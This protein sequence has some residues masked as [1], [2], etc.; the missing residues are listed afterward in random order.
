MSAWKPR[1]WRMTVRARIVLGHVLPMIP[2]AVLGLFT[3]F[4]LV[5]MTHVAN[6]TRTLG[7]ERM[8]DMASAVDLF[9]E[10]AV[11]MARHMESGDPGLMA[12]AK[13][14]STTL[15]THLALVGPLNDLPEDPL[16]LLLDDFE[17]L[18][19]MG[20]TM[21]DP[22]EVD[23]QARQLLRKMRSRHD[24]VRLELQ[25]GLKGL[26]VMGRTMATGVVLAVGLLVVSGTLMGLWMG[27]S[28]IDDLEVLERGTTALAA[29]DFDHRIQ[30]HREDEFGQLARAFNRMAAK[31]GAL[32]QMKADFFA[33][34]SH[35]LK[36]P[37][38]SIVEAVDLLE[39]EVAGPLTTRQRR[40]TGV[41]KESATRLKSLV[42]NLLDV[43]RIGARNLELTPGEVVTALKATISELSLLSARKE[44][45]VI[46]VLEGHGHVVLANR[47]MLEQVLMNVVGNAIRY[48]PRGGRVEVEVAHVGP[49]QLRVDGERGVRICVM[50]EGPGIPAA[51]R[52]QVFDRFF[53]VP[54]HQDRTGT[55]LGLYIARQIVESHGGIIEV[56][57]SPAG[58]AAVAFT[59]VAAAPLGV[60]PRPDELGE[61]ADADLETAE[62][63]TLLSGL[64]VGR[65][66]KGSE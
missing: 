15:R 44:V 24:R 41:L 28:L 57:T 52:E 10:E 53:R 42:A 50:D 31:I 61:V 49:E 40:L 33:N 19:G 8:D 18:S 62:G 30:L 14:R 26:G 16:V 46:L 21:G 38:T 36:T 48:S 2:I 27:R 58:G 23:R 4:A 47:G 39:E 1:P 20:G 11:L 37:L 9:R 22:E 6:E 3:V 59:L 32:D 43:S 45:E 29:G 7:L 5:R 13:R 63:A 51:Y 66:R 25:V 55:G 64:T 35:D 56:A 17:A 12:A 34:I 65:D 54:E 60:P